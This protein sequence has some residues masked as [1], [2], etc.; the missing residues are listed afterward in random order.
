[1][2]STVDVAMRLRAKAVNV[3]E[4]RFLLTVLT[5]SRQE[6]DLSEPVNCGGVGR[7]RHFRRDQS[8]GW[9]LNPL[10]I[11]PS[12]KALGI[13]AAPELRAQVFQNA[14]CNW[15][16]WYCFVPFELLAG[17]EA[18]SVWLEAPELVERYLSETDRA[19]LVDLSGGQPDLVPEWVPW[20]MDALEAA[21]VE[22]STYLW[23]DDNLSNDYFWRFL[24]PRQ[25]DRIAAYPAYGKVCCFK[26][27]DAESFAFNTSAPPDLFATQFDLFRRL[28]DL[29][30]DLYAYVTLTTPSVDGVGRK[31]GLLVDQLQ[32]IHPMLP[33]RTVPLHVVSWGPVHDRLTPARRKALEHQWAAV[34]SWQQELERRFT[35][36]ERA[37]NIASLP[38]P[39]DQ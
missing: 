23:S 37:T 28:A 16:C 33:L 11:D 22:S 30:L 9:P 13:A 15:R 38:R 24:S 17:R 20:M 25:I 19:A 3:A 1:V 26:G 27:F 31:V 2:Q 7:V 32:A 6:A 4:R 35:S 21:G 36:V 8:E 34:E 12:A 14:V 5:G 29:G 39:G 18:H 10:P